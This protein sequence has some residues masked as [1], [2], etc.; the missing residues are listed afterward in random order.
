MQAYPGG[1][2][3]AKRF[4]ARLIAGALMGQTAEEFAE[5]EMEIIKA[6]NEP[7]KVCEHGLLPLGCCAMCMSKQKDG[8]EAEHE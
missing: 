5:Q 1:T 7:L 6:R 3:R 2:G 4:L 8:E